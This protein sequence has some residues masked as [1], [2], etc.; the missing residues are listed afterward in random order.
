MWLDLFF[1]FCLISFIHMH[2]E[3][4]VEPAAKPVHQS[5]KLLNVHKR[6]YNEKAI[7][8][9]KQRLQKLTGQRA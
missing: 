7:E 2:D 3:V 5:Q 9:F 6:N 8:L 1:C 4:A